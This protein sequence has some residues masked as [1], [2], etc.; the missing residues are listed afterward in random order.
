MTDLPDR[1]AVLE[2]AGRIRPWVRETP[3]MAAEADMAGASGV[4]LKLECLQ[5]TGS[6]KARGAFNAMLAAPV[7]AEGVIAASGGNHGAAVAYAAMRLG[8][9]AVI[10]VPETAPAGKVARLRSYGAAVR[11]VGRMY[12]E[13]Y[14]AAVAHQA[15]T[16]ARMLHAYDQAE[17]LAGQGSA[18]V[19]FA[20]QAN[21]L[22]TMV[23][24]VGGGGLIGG[25]LAGLIGTGVKVVAVESEGT[26]TLHRALAEGAP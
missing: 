6:F 8:H 7:P 12:A 4:V 24:A 9:Q 16:G 22:D 3:V 15:V 18:G 21:G 1:D 5:R 17:I 11:Q 13:A 25:V 10:F 14:E 2:A 26:P 20:R 19:E 23:I